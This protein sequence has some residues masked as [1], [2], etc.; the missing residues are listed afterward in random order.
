MDNKDAIFQN[1]IQWNIAEVQT[2]SDE[3]YTRQI[4]GEDRNKVAPTKTTAEV[5]KKGQQYKQLLTSQ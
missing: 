2:R 5:G 3:E 4:P 1:N